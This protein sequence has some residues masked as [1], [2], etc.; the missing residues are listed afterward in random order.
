MAK[1]RWMPTSASAATTSGWTSKSLNSGLSGATGAPPSS[2]TVC[3]ICSDAGAPVSACSRRRPGA[4]GDGSVFS[5]EVSALASGLLGERVRRRVA[6]SDLSR[7]GCR[8]ISSSADAASRPGVE[9][10]GPGDSPRGAL[11]H[12]A[13]GAASSGCQRTDTQRTERLADCHGSAA[14]RV[15][16]AAPR[17]TVPGHQRV[18]AAP[19]ASPR[20]SGDL[21]ETRSTAAPSSTCWEC[22][23]TPN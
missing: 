3:S 10:F 18:R 1:V 13:R 14:H 12:R 20:P 8:G 21:C 19:R 9:G 4:V 11:D 7:V 22:S 2:S 16:S 5:V 15:A 6:A 23:P 17:T